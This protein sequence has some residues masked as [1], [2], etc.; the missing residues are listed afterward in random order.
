MENRLLA[1]YRSAAGAAAYR[2]KYRRSWAR[3]ISNR[4]ELSL[5]RRALRGIAGGRPKTV[6]DCP[7]GAGRLLPLLLEG[8]ERVWA[9]DLS[10][11]MIREARRASGGG[12]RVVFTQGSAVRLPFATGA[13]DVTLC[14][15]LIHHVPAREERAVILAE[16]ARVSRRAV[17]LSFA[18]AG[19]RRARR[20]KGR[21][22]CVTFTAR[23]LA[24]EAAEQGLHLVSPVRRLGGW[25]SFLAVAILERE[26]LAGGA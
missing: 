2:G 16:L 24:S 25:V 18:D 23:E 3:R 14:H 1:R 5:V 26:P 6:L 12:D 10:A 22:K 17:V 19:T 8:A 13:F 7:C 11:W 21:T 15:R 20:R 9:A 4:R